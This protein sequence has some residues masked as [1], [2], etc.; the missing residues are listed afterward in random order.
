MASREQQ[1]TVFLTS[2]NMQE[3]EALCDQLALI[4]QGRIVVTGS[5]TNVKALIGEKVI[6][7]T[8][9]GNEQGISLLKDEIEI[10]VLKRE[11][12]KLTAGTNKVH[13]VISKIAMLQSH[14]VKVTSINVAEPTLEDVF[15]KL[16]EEDTIKHAKS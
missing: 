9:E 5:P 13:S 1:A 11:D 3:V 10:E 8:Y 16:T 15:L 7:I 14:G 2:H 6:T 12:G 4:N